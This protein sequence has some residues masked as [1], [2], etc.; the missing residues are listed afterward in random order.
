VACHAGR[1]MNLPEVSLMEMG[2]PK[3]A[4]SLGLHVLVTICALVALGTG[5][6][7]ADRVVMCEEFTNIT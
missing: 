3:R 2:I 6:L 7:A 1:R 5:G 4:C